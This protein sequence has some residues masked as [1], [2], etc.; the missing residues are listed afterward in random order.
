MPNQPEESVPDLAAI[1]AL[2]A[3]NAA[4]VR[5]AAD[6]MRDLILAAVDASVEDSA[7]LLAGAGGLLSAVVDAV[8]QMR[9]AELRLD[10]ISVL[11]EAEQIIGGRQ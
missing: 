9:A 8:K 2:R 6:G 1:V 11:A 4:Q 5:A 3:A 7:V 10:S